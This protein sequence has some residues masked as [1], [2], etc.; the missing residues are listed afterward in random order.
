KPKEIDWTPDYTGVNKIPYGCYVIKELLP[1]SK[2]GLVVHVNYE[3]LNKALVNYPQ[4]A[5]S[6]LIITESFSPD[7]LEI[8]ELFKYLH[9]GNKVLVSA[10]N[11]GKYFT[12]TFR[13]TT[14]LEV[15]AISHLRKPVQ[16]NLMNPHLK[17]PVF[18]RFQG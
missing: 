17:S 18:Y 3:S 6:M 5:S 7:S 11:F 8:S 14:K 9:R 2:P 1:E 4:P 10:I 15:S 13:I 12:D 16:L